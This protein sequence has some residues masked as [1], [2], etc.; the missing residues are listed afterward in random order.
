MIKLDIT[1]ISNIRLP[2]GLHNISSESFTQSVV[3]AVSVGPQSDM[4]RWLHLWDDDWIVFTLQPIGLHLMN[5]KHHQLLLF[6]WEKRNILKEKKEALIHLSN[7]IICLGTVPANENESQ[8]FLSHIT[9][10]RHEMVNS[11]YVHT[12]PHTHISSL[13]LRPEKVGK[14]SSTE[15]GPT[16]LGSPWEH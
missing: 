5:S 13:A 11:I 9:L 7:E 16:T 10:N 1:S 12:I 14:P 2:A 15:A 6:L 3:R 8:I 4:Q